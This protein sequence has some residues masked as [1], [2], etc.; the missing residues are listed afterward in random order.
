MRTGWS[1]LLA[2][3]VVS[4]AQKNTT[5]LGIKATQPSSPSSAPAA[6]ENL[7]KGGGGNNAK[8]C[9]NTVTVTAGG[10]PMCPLPSTVT[11]KTTVTTC[12]YGDC[13][14]PSKITDTKTITDV[15]TLTTTCT[16]KTT[17]IE[18]HNYTTTYTDHVTTVGHQE[19]PSNKMYANFCRPFQGLQLPTIIQ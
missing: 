19:M 17:F 9:T 2:F 11:S 18:T 7:D 5:V 15:K 4:F 16:E 13:P 3:A 1:F 8:S 6:V 12:G 14:K 10:Y